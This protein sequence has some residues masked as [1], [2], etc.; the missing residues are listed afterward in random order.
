MTR[1][2]DLQRAKEEQNNQIIASSEKVEFVNSEIIFSGL[3]NTAIIEDDT[4]I[5]NSRITFSGNNS[6]IYISSSRHAAM[7]RANLHNENVIYIGKNN[8]FNGIIDMLA[9]EQRHI[10][11]G[12]NCLLSY[13]I[14]IRTADPHLI[15]DIATS[16]R[17]NQSKD[18]LIGDHVWIGQNVLVLKGSKIHSGAI[19]G[20]N[21]VVTAT[22]H[23]RS[24]EMWAGN[25]AKK[26]RE[27]VFWRGDCVHMWTQQHTEKFY[28]VEDNR[29]YVFEKDKY[30]LP[31]EE[32]SSWITDI[33]NY[34]HHNRFFG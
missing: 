1:Y 32:I 6:K 18:V 29:E 33:Q 19:I 31:Y 9:S 2:T 15:Y 12:N 27:G 25:P 10:V 13:G 20:G 26:V 4:K 14:T 11:I 17:I 7:I 8:Y 5:I 23:I 22:R 3:G 28:H 16:C 30:T 21:S 24:N 34:L